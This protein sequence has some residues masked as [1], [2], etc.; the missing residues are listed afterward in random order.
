MKHLTVSFYT[1]ELPEIAAG[2][3]GE[4]HDA[5]HDLLQQV[6]SPDSFVLH[7]DGAAAEL[8]L[9]GN[10]A[11]VDAQGRPYF[12]ATALMS[13]REYLVAARTPF[14]VNES[15]VVGWVGYRVPLVRQRRAVQEPLAAVISLELA[16]QTR[17]AEAVAGKLT[18]DAAIM[19]VAGTLRVLSEGLPSLM[20]CRFVAPHDAPPV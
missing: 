3:L 20:G 10:G 17:S 19:G 9:P 14:S 11:L 2:P 18:A 8:A 7:D 12:E 6:Q 13:S 16:C 4:L 1:R 15:L 5:T